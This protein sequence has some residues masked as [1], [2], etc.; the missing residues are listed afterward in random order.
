[1]PVRGWMGLAAGQ[2]LALFH[3]LAPGFKNR[4]GGPL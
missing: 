4:T 2:A 3:L 1:M